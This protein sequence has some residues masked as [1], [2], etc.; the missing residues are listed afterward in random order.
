MFA[1]AIAK[2]LRAYFFETSC[3]ML[4]DTRA[5]KCGNVMHKVHWSSYTQH[6]TLHPFDNN[7]SSSPIA[8]R[9]HADLVFQSIHYKHV[10]KHMR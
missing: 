7:G 4:R 5:A 3:I 6:D 10:E 8:T 2:A 9:L 1:N